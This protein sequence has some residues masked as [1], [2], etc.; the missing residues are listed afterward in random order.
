MKKDTNALNEIAKF[1]NVEVS[2]LLRLPVEL[3]IKMQKA[4]SDSDFMLIHM[5][6]YKI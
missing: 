6:G 3:L 4:F 5:L 1:L 2:T